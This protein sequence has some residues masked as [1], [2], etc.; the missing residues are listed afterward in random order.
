MAVDGV[1]V[2]GVEDVADDGAG[3]LRGEDNG[4]LLGLDPPRTQ[5]AQRAAGGLLANVNGI[6]QQHGGA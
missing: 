4:G 2:G 3:D 5:P 6:V 1:A